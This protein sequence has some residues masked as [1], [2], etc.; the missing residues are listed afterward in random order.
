MPWMAM[1][2]NYEFPEQ[3]RIIRK[4]LDDSVGARNRCSPHCAFAPLQQTSEP[5]K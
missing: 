1:E 2:K 4:R 5:A 3:L